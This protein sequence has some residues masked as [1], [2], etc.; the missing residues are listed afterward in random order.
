MC[1]ICSL[2]LSRAVRPTTA[3]ATATVT[4]TPEEA[5]PVTQEEK[6]VEKVVEKK[7]RAPNDWVR[8]CQQVHAKTKDVSYKEVL[9][10][11]G[12]HTNL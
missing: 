5:P 7:K 11:E 1:G 3:T 4:T 8:Q 12:K 2:L 9:K 6:T 10:T